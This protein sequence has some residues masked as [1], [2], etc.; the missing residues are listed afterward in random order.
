MFELI[1]TFTKQNTSSKP[2]PIIILAR[3]KMH[4]LK[5]AVIVSTQ[6][7]RT[8][9]KFTKKDNEKEPCVQVTENVI[10]T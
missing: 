1:K 9:Y 6:F 3:Q 2:E 10:I 5:I 8:R 4:S 7:M